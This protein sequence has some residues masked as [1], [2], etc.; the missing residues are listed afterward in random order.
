MSRN[1]TTEC[2][3]AQYTNLLPDYPVSQAMTAD[4]ALD[5]LLGPPGYRPSSDL[6]ALVGVARRALSD[7][8]RGDR[9]LAADRFGWVQIELSE[10]LELRPELAPL[11]QLA[12]TAAV[13]IGKCQPGGIAAAVTL[14]SKLVPLALRGGWFHD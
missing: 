9:Q 7:L 4:E 6:V 11:Q 5:F 13:R 1:N 2:A 12:A 3:K 8:N 10:M 14:V